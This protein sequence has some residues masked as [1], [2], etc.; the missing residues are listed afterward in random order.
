MVE[1]VIAEVVSLSFIRH[2][3]Y[4]SKLGSRS[5]L[6]LALKFMQTGPTKTP[7]HPKKAT[8]WGRKIKW[9]VFVPTS[10]GATGE[11]LCAGRHDQGSFQLLKKTG[12]FLLPARPNPPLPS[13]TSHHGQRTSQISIIS[14][15][16]SSRLRIRRTVSCHHHHCSKPHEN[17]TRSF[18]RSEMVAS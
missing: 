18:V 6:C 7:L 15:R 5:I 2:T 14:S 17:A 4:T 10:S 11:L 13:A 12:S 9:L 16:S 8:Q 1:K 3:P